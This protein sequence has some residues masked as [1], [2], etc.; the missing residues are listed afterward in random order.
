V[1]SSTGCWAQVVI[2]SRHNSVKEKVI[3]AT[4]RVRSSQNSP[5][6]TREKQ[7][8]WVFKKKIRRCLHSEARLIRRIPGGMLTSWLYVPI[9]K[10]ILMSIHSGTVVNKAAETSTL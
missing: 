5:F 10:K 6:L 8:M 9:R 3:M 7:I 4:P 1:P 2:K